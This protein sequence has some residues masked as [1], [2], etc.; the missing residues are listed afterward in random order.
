V[1]IQPKNMEL[2]AN[3]RA[4]CGRAMVDGRAYVGNQETD[5]NT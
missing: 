5:Q 4:I 2:S 1:G 3:S